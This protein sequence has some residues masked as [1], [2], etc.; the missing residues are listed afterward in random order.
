MMKNIHIV[1]LISLILSV[2]V[3]INF[4]FITKHRQGIGKLAV[5]LTAKKTRNERIDKAYREME[6]VLDSLEPV[7]PKISVKIGQNNSDQLLFPEMEQLG[8]DEK[9]IRAS[10][11]GKVFF[12]VLE[13]FFPVFKEPNWFDAYDPPLSPEAN[14][15]LPYFD[16]YD[17]ANSSWTIYIR[18]RFGIY[19]WLDRL[20]LMPQATQKVFLRADGKTVWNDGFYGDWYI[21]PAINYFQLE[22]HF[23]RGAGASQGQ[24]GLRVFQVNRWNYETEIGR[25]W[26]RGL[27]SYLRNETNFW[28]LEGR[29]WGL[30]VSWRPFPRDQGKFVAIRD[31]TNLTAVFGSERNTPWE[32]RFLHAASL[33]FY[34]AHPDQLERIEDNFNMFYTNL[35]GSEVR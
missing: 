35:F 13:F 10:P 7:K 19:N 33:P 30:A 26:Q 11:F 3:K 8:I 20:G 28:A 2:L 18:H 12:P 29:V 1:L 4:S 21:N 15:E 5:C 31:G 6:D 34:Q 17:F 16:G 23:G 27:R 25:Y 32:E 14:M 9:K 24:R 22:K